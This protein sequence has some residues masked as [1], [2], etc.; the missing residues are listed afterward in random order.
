MMRLLYGAGTE[1]TKNLL[2]SFIQ[3]D[4]ENGKRVVLLV[5]EQEAVIT[6]QRMLKI[7][8]PSAQLS[9]EVLNFSRLANRVFRTVGGLSY[10]YASP[11][12]TNLTMWRVLRHLSPTLKLFGK[13]GGDRA[14]TE[15][16]LS[17]VAQCKA[18][19]ISPDVLANAADTLPE[20]DPLRSKLFDIALVLG[21]YS[22]DLATQ[23]DDVDDDLSRAADLIAA[24]RTLFAVLAAP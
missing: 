18:Y 22:A 6:E 9:F 11:A 10:R 12:V 19:C 17:A 3:S 4:V 13:N 1:N 21:S 7:L 5:P 16:M 24:N 14:L 8:P 23:F 2:T 15:R 20:S